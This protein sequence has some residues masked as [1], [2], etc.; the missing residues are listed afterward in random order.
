MKRAAGHELIR[1]AGSAGAER[2]SSGADSLDGTRTLHAQSRRLELSFF[3]QRVEG[4]LY[5]E[6]EEIPRS[7]GAT[8]QVQSVRFADRARFE[9]WCDDDPERFE[10][11]ALFI[12]LRRVAD[13]LWQ[14]GLP[15]S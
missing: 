3:L 7:E 11:P 9:Q 1:R 2:V 12:E 15:V 6:R 10:H 13:E 5:V 8:V 4:G 14:A